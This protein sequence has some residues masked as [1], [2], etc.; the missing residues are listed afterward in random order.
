[1]SEK[2]RRPSRRQ[3]LRTL[4]KCEAPR[5][6]ARDAAAELRRREL[7]RRAAEMLAALPTQGVRPH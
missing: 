4:S 3:A 2:P 6:S 5:K 1:M 7:L